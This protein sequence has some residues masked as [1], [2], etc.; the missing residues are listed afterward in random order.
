[1]IETIKVTAICYE[2]GNETKKP[3]LFAVT[4]AEV[5]TQTRQGF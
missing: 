3:W 2:C 4:R 1:M 5:K